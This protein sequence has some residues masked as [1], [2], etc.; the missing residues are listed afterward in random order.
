MRNENQRN[1]RMEI[2]F[3]TVRRRSYSA[4][5]FV[6]FTSKSN[7]T[8]LAC[9]T[10]KTRRPIPQVHVPLARPGQLGLSTLCPPGEGVFHSSP[11][12]CTSLADHRC[13]LARA[14]R[15]G[16]RSEFHV[17]TYPRIHVSVD[18]TALGCLQSV[19]LTFTDGDTLQARGSVR[20]TSLV[21]ASPTGQ[22]KALPAT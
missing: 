20:P 14:R 1:L 22:T 6:T 8:F 2:N 12:C 13:A 11:G 16:G 18:K 17:S 4:R 21:Q 10:R 9:P 7:L 15:C 3:S 5:E 19:D